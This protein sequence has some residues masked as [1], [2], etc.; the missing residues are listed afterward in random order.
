M[1]RTVTG[2]DVG[3]RTAKLLR[4]S[5]KGNTLRVTNFAVTPLRSPRAAT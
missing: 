1:A 3:L 2:V 5:W 4:G